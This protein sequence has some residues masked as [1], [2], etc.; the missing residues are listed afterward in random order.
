MD[1]ETRPTRRI[2]LTL[3]KPGFAL[4]AGIR[5]TVVI[6]ERGQPAQWGVGTWQVPADGAVV[7][8]F[9]YNRRWRF[10]RAEI[11]LGSRHPLAVEYRAPA[12]PFLRGRIRATT[13][14]A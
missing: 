4:F 11:V 5:P 8:V 10:G 9:L 14:S 6:G 2:E 1:T 3:R 12:L 13:P 7:G